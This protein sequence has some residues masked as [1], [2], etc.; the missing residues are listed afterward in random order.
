[1]KFSAV[2]AFAVG[3]L[4]SVVPEVEKRASVVTLNNFDNTTAQRL[5]LVNK[6]LGS[7]SGLF[8]KGIGVAQIYDS[9]GQLQAL[10]L[11]SKSNAAVYGNLDRLSDDYPYITSK[12]SGSLLTTFDLTS[13]SYGCIIG[14]LAAN[15]DIT[16]AAYRNSVRVAGQTLRFTPANRLNSPLATIT[17]GPTFRNIDSIRFATSFTDSSKFPG[18]GGA[19]FLDDLSYVLNTL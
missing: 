6:Q 11:R 7:S 16:I 3:A 13:L 19:T 5:N 8:Y 9:F 18:L 12:F 17:L 10:T 1:M 15:C 4:A 14:N 2:F